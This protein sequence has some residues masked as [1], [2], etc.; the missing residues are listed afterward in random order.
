VT[1]LYWAQ[2]PLSY[3][4]TPPFLRGL[5]S[6]TPESRAAYEELSDVWERKRAALL[7]MFVS[8][9]DLDLRRSIIP[10]LNLDPE[11][12]PHALHPLIPQAI[13]IARCS[14]DEYI[15][16]RVEIQ[17]GEFGPLMA[18]PHRPERSVMDE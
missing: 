3:S 11:A 18:L 16:H 4:G 13:A 6:A 12:Y 10:T 1:A 7:Q 8:N 14:D 17:L 15:R 9:N 2:V 5:E